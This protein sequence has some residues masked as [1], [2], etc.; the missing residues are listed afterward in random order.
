MRGVLEDQ[1]KPYQYFGTSIMA[2]LGEEL[3]KAHFKAGCPLFFF[4][5][6]S[7]LNYR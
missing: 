6:F 2:F 5:K 1:A 4:K 7:Y 3:T